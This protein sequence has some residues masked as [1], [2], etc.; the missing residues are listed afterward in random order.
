MEFAYVDES[1][2][3]GTTGTRTF[4]LGCVL[5]PVDGWFGRLDRLVA[6]R[7]EFRDV[8]RLPLRQEAK[9]NHLVGVKKIYRDLGLGDSIVDCQDG[10]MQ[11]S[12]SAQIADLPAHTRLDISFPPWW[13]RVGG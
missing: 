12:E 13:I 9:A 8:Y 6:M 3:T 10:R 7:R 1:G 5:V 2:D 4:T 11:D